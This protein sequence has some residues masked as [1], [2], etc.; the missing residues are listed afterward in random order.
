MRRSFPS[1][2]L[3]SARP[4]RLCARDCQLTRLVLIRFQ[5]RKAPGSTTVRCDFS[6]ANPHESAY[7]LSVLSRFDITL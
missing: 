3:R 6:T 1:K 2:V 5:K 4:V 7:G